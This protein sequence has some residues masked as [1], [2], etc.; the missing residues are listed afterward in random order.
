MNAGSNLFSTVEQA[1][2]WMNGQTNS[3]QRQGL[4]KIKTALDYLGNPHKQL[5]TIHISGT[6]GK[7]SVSAYLKQLFLAH[8]MTVGTFTSPH[9]MRFN[10][11]MTYNHEEISD[12]TLMRLMN[13]LVSM[14]AYMEQT[15]YG[16][17]VY[18]ELYTVLMF[19]FFQE[20]QPD[21]CLIEVGI[22]GLLDCTNVIESLD[23]VI[24]TV[25]LDHV[26]KLG[27]TYEEI[28]TQKAGIIYSNADVYVGEL[29]ETA[30]SAVKVVCHENAATLY[31]LPQVQPYNVLTESLTEGTTFTVAEQVYTIHLLGRHQVHNAAL[32]R[33]VFVNWMQKNK[34]ML[35]EDKIHHALAVTKWPARM[36]KISNQPLIYIDGAHNEAGIKALG[37]TIQTHFSNQRVSVLYAGLQTKNQAEHL[38]LLQS[39]PLKTLVLS[40][41]DHYQAM[42][43]EQFKMIQTENKVPTRFE[44]D[45]YSVLNSDHDAIWIVTGSLYFVSE[46]RQQFIN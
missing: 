1:L 37:Q 33:L 16:R 46:V 34:Q 12:E 21:I 35:A 19:L 43:A 10:E 17:L 25:A 15:D 18:F 39:M 9:I 13:Q 24:T 5:K 29:P 4:D 6:N 44:S 27:A 41:F 14:N 3:V 23:V 45:W 22:G 20:M 2:S 28:A 11:R 42:S 40:T 36:E 26:D 8:G 31:H 7:G 38:A 32:A 30:L